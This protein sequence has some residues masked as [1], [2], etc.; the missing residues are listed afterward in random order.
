M[1]IPPVPRD[2][3]QIPRAP[4]PGAPDRVRGE[5]PGALPLPAAFLLALAGA[6]AAVIVL[7]AP[8]LPASLLTWPLAVSLWQLSVTPFCRAT[9]IYLYHSPML[10]ATFRSSR[11]WEV[12]GGTTWDWLVLFRFRDRGAPSARK[13]M[14]WYLEGFLDVADRVERGEI[15]AAIEVTGTSWF[16][17]P[18]TAERL[19]FEIRPAGFRL[20]FNLLL[21]ALDLWLTYSF[22]R[23]RF[24]VPALLDVKQAVI[25]GDE[26]VRRRPQIARL[27]ATL[28][29]KP[30]GELRRSCG[31]RAVRGRRP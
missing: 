17:R 2:S 4:S 24:A 21:N 30:R 3:I 6:S 10:K 28:G 8:G 18:G 16:F 19:G 12:H 23:A 7:V 20:R 14:I 31:L 13:V 5:A 15:P 9:G 1:T 27:C 25:R 22:T 26:L 11:I 29:R